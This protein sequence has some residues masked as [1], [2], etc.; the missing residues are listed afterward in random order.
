MKSAAK[1]SI[2][3][4]LTASDIDVLVRHNE[5][6]GKKLR[7][8]AVKSAFASVAR[9]VAAGIGSVAGLFAHGGKP[10]SHGP[11]AA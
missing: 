10:A 7:A 5:K 1:H 9:T 8:E 4:H 6:V 3:D 2:H 11:S